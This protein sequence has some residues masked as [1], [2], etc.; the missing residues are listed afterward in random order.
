[1]VDKNELTPVERCRHVCLVSVLVADVEAVVVVCQLSLQGHRSCDGAPPS[2]LCLAVV[3][4]LL[5]YRP[6]QGK[7]GCVFDP[8]HTQ[9]HTKLLQ[10]KRSL[11]A[12][13]FP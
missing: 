8:V 7:Q 4:E 6:L 11:K 10:F 1:M 12:F 13:L 9:R 5:L 2:V 3:Q